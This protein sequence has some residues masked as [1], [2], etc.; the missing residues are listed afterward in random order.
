[1]QL[2]PLYSSTSLLSNMYVYISLLW[3]FSFQKDLFYKLWCFLWY[4]LNSVCH[5]SLWRSLF[6]LPQ[7]S[8][9]LP[10]PPWW[11]CGLPPWLY[12]ELLQLYYRGR[13]SSWNRRVYMLGHM[14]DIDLN[15]S[16]CNM[17]PSAGSLFL[18][19]SLDKGASSTPPLPLLFL[20]KALTASSF[21]QIQLQ[22]SR[23]KLSVTMQ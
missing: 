23:E 11:H 6:P 4:I 3:R 19:Q 13:T 1:M 20:L 14:D 21:N 16:T 5:A 18:F 12:S 22:F 10:L 2:H 8:S 17:L 9:L 15:V 7:V